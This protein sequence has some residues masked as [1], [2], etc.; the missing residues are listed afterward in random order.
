MQTK[1]HLIYSGLD[2][3]FSTET[4][5]NYNN[6]IVSLAIKYCNR[7][8]HCV[9]FGAGIG[10]LSLIFREKFNI[11]PVCIEVDQ[12]NTSF[13]TKRGFSF[14]STLD[15]TDK[16]AD[17]IFSSNVLEH[18]ED[19]AEILME[20]NKHLKDDGYLFLYLPAHMYLW[21]EMD[22]AVGHYRRYSSN[23]LKQK[24]VT[25][26]FEIDKIHYADSVGF[27]ASFAL[28]Y[29]GHNPK[30]G[31]GSTASLKFYDRFI[32]PIS[33]ALDS[34]GLRHFIGKNIVV[35]ARKRNL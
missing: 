13:L 11:E 27:I 23:D 8:E 4:M 30:T 17:L 5:L 14:S 34:L 20:M 10:T 18:I 12:T 29:L 35:S 28:K 24:L 26:G 33:K 15:S 2:E 3:L 16:P 31:I 19:D 25:A 32:F 7:P 6:H 21:S 1:D 22:D 9:D